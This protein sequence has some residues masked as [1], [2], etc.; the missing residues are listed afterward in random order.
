ML[1][2]IL[3]SIRSRIYAKRM[4]LRWRTLNSHNTTYLLSIPRNE[5]FFDKVKIGKM[6]YGP[7]NAIYSNHPNEKLVIGNYCS[8]GCDT[9]FILGSEHSYKGISTFPFK[10]KCLGEPFEALTKGPIIIEDDV[11]I[12]ENVLVLSG[13]RI[14]KGAIVAAGSIVVKDI[15]PYAIAGGNPSKIIRYR[16]S[17]EII[18]IL[19]KTDFY[20]LNCES[21][22]NN[23]GFLYEN[24][25]E[26]NINE[27]VRKLGIS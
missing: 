16:F 14:G 10:V 13:V 18:A 5:L 1:R 12:G 8:I 7:I 24:I 11:W 20:K 22:K 2:E 21:V 27:I 25:T 4:I 6:T 9:K 3:N 15:P 17:E 26:N 19:L 23:I